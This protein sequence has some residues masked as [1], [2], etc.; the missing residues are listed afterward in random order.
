[1]MGETTITVKLLGIPQVYKDDKV[2]RVSRKRVR[3]LLFYLAAEAKPIPR[4]AISYMLWPE[5]EYAEASQ[6][7]SIYLSYLKSEL[8]ENA[9]SSN[10]DMISLSPYITS[11]TQQFTALSKSE[12]IDDR[13]K[14]LSLFQGA[15]MNGFVINNA[16][17]FE[18]WLTETSAFWNSRFVE[19]S[20]DT[21]AALIKCQRYDEA[22]KLIEAAV[23]YDP[24]NEDLCQ[25]HMTVLSLA[26][27][28]SNVTYIYQS[29]ISL[30]NQELGL[31][32]SRKTSACYQQIIASDGAPNL[33]EEVSIR[34]RLT[35]SQDTIFV[36]RQASLLSMSPENSNRFVLIQ[37]KS[38]YGKTRLVTTYIQRCGLPSLQ[39]SFKQREQQS[40][41]FGII[42]SIRSMTLDP[43]RASLIKSI[44]ARLHPRRLDALCRLIPELCY[45]KAQLTHNTIITEQQIM[46]AF[47]QFL[48]LLLENQPTILFIDDIHYADQSSLELL[49][50]LSLQSSMKNVRFF[51]TFRPSL[52]HPGIISFLN[53]LQ[54]ENLLHILELSKLEE[55]DMSEL[56][57]YYYPDLDPDMTKELV[58]LA[59]GNP[60]WMRTIIEGLAS[61][62]TE[63]S[64]KSSLINLFKRSFDAI[65]DDA[66]S[67]AFM[68][69]LVGESFDAALFPALCDSLDVSDSKIYQELFLSNIL[70]KTN[71]DII[72]FSHSKVHEYAL[73][74]VNAKNYYVRALHLH[75]ATAMETV[76]G[77]YASIQQLMSISDHFRKS[78]Q[79]ERCAPYASQ[80]CS[81]LLSIAQRSEAIKYFKFAFPYLDSSDKFNML[82]VMYPYMIELGQ[83]YEAELYMAQAREL[84]NHLH[85]Y[86]YE[87]VFKAI[88][89]ISHY[90]EYLELYWGV[91][92]CYS[93]QVDTQIVNLLYEAKALLDSG[94]SNRFLANHINLF[95][96]YYYRLTGE[97]GKAATLLRKITIDNF[98]LISDN[99]IN[100]NILLY[101]AI[102]DEIALINQRFDQST[103]DIINLEMQ[104]FDSAPLH[105]FISANIGTQALLK[106]LHGHVEEGIQLMNSA[107][108]ESRHSASKYTLANNL[109]TQAMLIR[110]VSLVKSYSMNYEAYTIAKEINAQYTLVR[111]LAGLVIT[112]SS[113]KDAE[114]YYNELQRFA[115]NL[116]NDSISSKLESA[117]NALL[118]KA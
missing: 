104:L 111:S 64:G 83:N 62:Y 44:T 6:N 9:I 28:R 66:K 97:L 30:L 107:I 47:E 51:A 43:A 16:P 100:T 29:F 105:G 70:S 88:T 81:F 99:D 3:A 117:A 86:E 57:L 112:S 87:K 10:A 48:V 80:A 14:A 59:D 72:S 118:K 61:G 110:N 75:I 13:L 101:S 115:Q 76:Y 96:S 67:I 65:S 79:P 53:T 106:H 94:N 98:S 90:P 108:S 20:A 60:F 18:Q 41:Y 109:V 7:L 35:S 46:E 69:A 33:A 68:F 12:S 32:P 37:G 8:G 1:M 103:E 49:L 22:L 52:A 4:S 77:K 56:L 21:A 54:R 71:N 2:L 63:I 19:A 24:L 5:K 113:Y 15:F 73:S 116:G 82:L 40:P 23:R 58:S 39:I 91:T 45:D 25:L 85:A 93:V 36:G 38:G 89:I 34:P 42:K 17:A 92:P 27:K 50:Y 31:P 55:R 95:L 114:R 78:S 84:A 102:R 11:D 26:G 74:C